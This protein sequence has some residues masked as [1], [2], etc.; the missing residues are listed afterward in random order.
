MKH[1]FQ[2][3]VKRI[4][5]SP[6]DESTEDV[7]KASCMSRENELRQHHGADIL[8]WSNDLYKKAVEVTDHLALNAIPASNLPQYERPGLTL[9][10]VDASATNIDDVTA[11]CRHAI[12]GWYDQ[13]KDYDFAHP[14]LTEQDRDFAQ[15][16]WKA[17]KFVGV[18]RSLLPGGG[19]Y[20]ASVFQPAGE[21]QTTGTKKNRLFNTKRQTSHDKLHD[22]IDKLLSKKSH[23][24]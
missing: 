6:S 20:V 13:K 1:H 12:E 15:L 10:Y 19:S 18:S 5:L 16:V 14:S 24:P 17:S 4:C 22:L 11:T 7:M 2:I 21:Y 9:S 23:I 8:Q 3:I